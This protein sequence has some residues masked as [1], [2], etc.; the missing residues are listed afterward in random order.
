MIIGITGGIGCGKSTVSQI[1]ELLGCV[2]FNS[3][4]VAKTIYFETEIKNKVLRLLGPEAYL[5]NAQLNKPFISSKI[6][7][8]TDLLQKLNAIIHPAV[9]YKFGEFVKH[10]KAKLILKETALLF[11][12]HLESGCDK[13]IVVAAND[14]LRIKRVMLRDKLSK[15]AV[16]KK[17]QSQLSQEEKIK[18]ADYVI[19][20]NEDKLVI[21]Q[22]TELFKLLNSIA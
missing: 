4:E 22:V 10:S 14:E 9:M 21:P 2:V 8:N 1:F 13:I 6:F 19:T 17:I 18:K 3:D 15:E 16:L 20:N 12:A 5:S 11:E 7:S